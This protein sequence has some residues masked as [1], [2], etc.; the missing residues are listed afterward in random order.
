M[1]FANFCDHNIHSV[2][3]HVTMAKTRRQHVVAVT[4]KSRICYIN[5]ELDS[6]W[7]FIACYEYI[8]LF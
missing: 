3:G 1:T 8:I 5:Y 2:Q 7:H 4:T 6:V